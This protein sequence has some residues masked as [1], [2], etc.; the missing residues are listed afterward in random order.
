MSASLKNRRARPRTTAGRA[1]RGCGCCEAGASPRARAGRRHQAQPDQGAVDRSCRRCRRRSRERR[2]RDLRPGHRL[3]HL[4][5]CDTFPV[6]ISPASP[7]QTCTADF[8]SCRT[9]RRRPVAPR[10]ARQPVGDFVLPEEGSDDPRLAALLRRRR[11]RRQHQPHNGEE[12]QAHDHASE[13]RTR[14][15]EKLQ[16]RHGSPASR[17]RSRRPAPRSCLRPLDE[18]AE[19]GEV[20]HKRRDR[21]HQEAHPLV[22]EVAAL[23]EG[24]HAVQV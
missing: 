9:R 23:A 3:D 14:F 21:D 10:V 17:A 13:E 11:R 7:D 4:A 15:G 20:E 6:A 16:S 2:P 22:G 1:G 24:P 8:R 12:Q 19:E 5:A 18:D